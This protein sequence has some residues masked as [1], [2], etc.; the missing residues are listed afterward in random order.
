MTEMA[1]LSA[2]CQAEI[3]FLPRRAALWENPP[4]S[5]TLEILRERL[6]ERRRAKGISPRALSLAIGANHSYIAQ[7]LSGK[8]GI[9]SADKL[10]AIAGVLETTSEHLLGESDYPG[11]IRSEVTLADRHMDWR[12]PP[13]GERGVPLHGSGDCAEMHFDN[14]SGELVDIEGS[15]FDMDHEIRFVDRPPAL[16]GNSKA[17]AIWLH[18]DSMAPRCRAGDVAYVDPR[19][20]S[21][22]G[23]LVVVQ[24]NNGEH[25]GVAMVLVKTLVRQSAR[26]IVLEQHNPPR[27]FVVPR[28]RVH[29]LHRIVMLET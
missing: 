16:R 2:V 20:P 26:E 8:G 28:E 22:P 7:L 15:S 4:V 12:G 25:D 6:E 19:R 13:P 21:G 1:D 9:P 29:H 18:G 11:P 5:D 17:Y 23:D 14:E 24:L 10:R 3:P 27:R